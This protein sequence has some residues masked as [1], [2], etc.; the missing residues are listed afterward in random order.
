[1]TRVLCVAEKPSIAKS[2]AQTLGGGRV[3]LR[4]SGNKYVKNYDFRFEFPEW[5][6]CDVTMTSVLGHLTSIDFPESFAWG[7]CDPDRLFQAPIMTKGSGSDSA[8]VATNITNEAQRANHLMIWTDCD[9]EGEYIG[10]EIL[11][12]AKKKNGFFNLNNTYRAQFSHLE[13]SHI[14]RAAKNPIKLNKNAID[15]VSTRM[16]VDL[17]TGAS[18]TRF[19]TETFRARFKDTV[20][21]VVSYGACQ[22]PTLGFV[23]DRYKRVK[24]FVPEEFWYLSIEA[25]KG[26]S[27]VPLTWSKP[28]LFDRLV[29]LV[30][31]Q[32][33]VQFSGNQATVTN[34]SSRPTSNWAPLPLTTVELQKCCSNIFKMGAKETVDCAEKLYNMGFISYPRTETDKFP[35]NMDFKSL[36]EKHAQSSTW[37]EYAAALANEPGK[38]RTPRE[39]SHDDKAHPPIHPICFTDGASLNAKQKQVYEFVVRRFLACC[40]KDATGSLTTVKVRWGTEDFAASGLN[41]IETNYLDIYTYS[42][43]E[44]SKKLP[45]FEMGE[46]INLSKAEL[47]TGRTSP[48]EY[49]TESEL[50]ALMDAN[51][52]GTDA[53]IAEHIEKILTREYAVKVPK[54]T[55]RSKVLQIVPTELGYGLVEGFNQIGFDRI[56]LTKPFLR[57]ELEGKLRNIVDGQKRKQEVLEEIIELYHQAFVQTK[58]NKS[59]VLDSY[60]KIVESNS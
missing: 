34:V 14:V 31:Y 59:V 28:S 17:R 5:G 46:I 48:P 26:N 37:G 15:A 10:F 24:S 41:V 11:E 56:S 42:K 27:K 1:M 21:K 43:W 16:E 58:Q 53:T 57:R 52:I 2:V 18:F 33:C 60:R 39:G 40:S 55:G 36:I 4:E 12:Q 20:P 6:W 7:N 38:F 29:A 30:I 8:K 54:G 9:R 19:L 25:K 49:L 22:F 32:E 3:S 35:K 51:E 50:I 44:S 47:A 13:R 23:V 45:A